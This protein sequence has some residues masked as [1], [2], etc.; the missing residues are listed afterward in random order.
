MTPVDLTPAIDR[1]IGH[2]MAVDDRIIVI[3]EDVPALRRSLTAQFGS[4]R[5]IEA[6]ISESAFLGAGVGAALAGL[7]PIVEIM[8]V[9]FLSVALHQVANEAVMLGPFSNGK[10]SVPLMIRSACGGGYGDAGQHEQTLWGMLSGL[11]EL[12]VVAPSN[13][14]DA[15]G[16]TLSLLN[17]DGPS[18]LLEHKL[19]SASWREEM[20]GTHR[21]GLAI[22]VPSGDWSQPTEMEPIPLGEAVVR[23]DGEDAVIITAAVG[24]HRS[25]TAAEMMK[26]RGLSVGVVDLR[27]ISPLDTSTI[28]ESAIRAGAVVVVDEDYEGFGLSG[29]VAAVLLEAGVHRPFARVATRGVIP[30]ARHLEEETLPSVDRIV[31][32]VSG[33]LT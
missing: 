11:P 16:L 20:G 32:A 26:E 21:K 14:H 8:F 33:L 13:P 7:R 29:E 19:L 1:A 28:V 23:R 6:P 2:A 5:V 10:W 30:Y 15:A 17:H 25:L 4:D 9:D 18:V 12:S 3:G 24:V 27:C 31:A 22:D